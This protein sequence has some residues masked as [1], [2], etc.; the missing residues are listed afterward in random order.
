[1]TRHLCYL[2][3]DQTSIP[4]E[5]CPGIYTT[6]EVSRPPYHLR[7]VQTPIPPERYPG[8]YTY[9]SGYP[10][11]YTSWLVTRYSYNL[12][13]SQV[14]IQPEQSHRALFSKWLFWHLGEVIYD[15]SRS[16]LGEDFFHCILRE[17]L[18]GLIG[19]FYYASPEGRSWYTVVWLHDL[20]AL[21]CIAWHLVLACR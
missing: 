21:H 6:W 7:G 9:L 3:D 11:T 15:W 14:S 2:R 19:G 1:M 10:G 5:R 18:L 20:R 12:S 13:G 17:D 8:T 16:V 4:P